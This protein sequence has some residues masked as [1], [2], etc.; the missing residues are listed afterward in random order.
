MKILHFGVVCNEENWNKI[1][2]LSKSKASTAPLVFNTLI[3]KGLSRNEKIDVVTFP[4]IS[5]FPGSLKL[6]WFFKKEEVLPGLYTQWLPTI[7]V[8]VIKQICYFTSTIIFRSSR[9]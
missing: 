4:P 6:G 9:T 7:N 2:E 1:Q 3:L 8:P 5:T